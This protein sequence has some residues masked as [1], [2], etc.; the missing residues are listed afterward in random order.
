MEVLFMNVL[1]VDKC[2]IQFR[3]Q[4]C[5]KMH[6]SVFVSKSLSE[7]SEG[8]NS[9]LTHSSTTSILHCKDSTDTSLYTLSSTA[10]V[11][12]RLKVTR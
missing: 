1:T 5:S 2:K 10:Q 12:R 6:R 7:S 3:S 8:R 9:S 4:K 11:N